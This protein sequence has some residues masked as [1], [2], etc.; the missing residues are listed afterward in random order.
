MISLIRVSYDNGLKLSYPIDVK[1]G[2]IRQ[3]IFSASRDGLIR[4]I[5][6]VASQDGGDCDQRRMK[7]VKVY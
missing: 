1:G 4:R 3:H 2:L 5:G 6:L 7:L